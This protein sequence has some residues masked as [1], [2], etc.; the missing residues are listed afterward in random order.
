MSDTVQRFLFEHA[1]V[2]CE[3]VHLDATWRAV[4]ERHEYP[5]ALQQLLGDAYRAFR[6]CITP[7]KATGWRHSK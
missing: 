2:R 3:L 7:A 6:L 4:L 5:R 1:P